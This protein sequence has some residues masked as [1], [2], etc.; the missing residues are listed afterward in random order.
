MN[1]RSHMRVGALVQVVFLIAA[2]ALFWWGSEM[3]IDAIALMSLAAAFLP[4]I[5]IMRFVLWARCHRRGSAS[6]PVREEG[7]DD[8]AAN[9]RGEDG[10]DQI[11]QDDHAGQVIAFPRDPVGVQ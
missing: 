9:R 10:V 1:P 4:P 3:S 7:A 6:S 11:D 5:V 8:G 2:A